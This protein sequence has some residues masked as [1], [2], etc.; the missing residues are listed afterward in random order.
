MKKIIIT[1]SFEIKWTATGGTSLILDTIELT[2]DSNL[3]DTFISKVEIATDIPVSISLLIRR[4]NFSL[5]C[6]DFSTNFGDTYSTAPAGVY[7]S[8]VTKSP[9]LNILEIYEGNSMWEGFQYWSG[10]KITLNV[11]IQLS[12]TIGIGDTVTSMVNITYEQN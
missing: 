2:P 5:E 6:E 9:K 7:T 8:V 11:Q 10:S 3:K 4:Q 12:N 1:K